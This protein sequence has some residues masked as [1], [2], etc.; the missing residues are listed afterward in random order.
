MVV[1]LTVAASFVY[2]T[3][4]PCTIHLTHIMMVGGDGGGGG[5]GS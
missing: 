5:G 4:E 3:T 2:L 1:E